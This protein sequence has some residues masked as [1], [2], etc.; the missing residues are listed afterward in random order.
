[1]L[2]LQD[3]T[4][5][6]IQISVVCYVAR[7]SLRLRWRPAI[8]SRTEVALWWLGCVAYLV[9]VILAFH[10]FHD[11]SHDAAVV[12]TAEETARLTGIRN[13]QGVWL[14]YAFA[15]IWIAD[16]VRLQRCLHQHRE[17]SPGIDAIVAGFFVLMMFS[18]T[19]VFGP[20]AYRWLFALLLPLWLAL[21]WQ[22]RRQ[23]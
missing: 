13:G 17:T 14:N 12:F 21:W 16:C 20:V 23:P 2:E 18:A 3:L 5:L 6:V 11:W 8:P 15:V 19:V 4:R 7:I 1:M 9:H 22:A 10:S